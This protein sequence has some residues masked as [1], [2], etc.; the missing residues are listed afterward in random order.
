MFLTDINMTWLN[1]DIVVASQLIPINF[2]LLVK[3]RYPSHR[4]VGLALL[5]LYAHFSPLQHVSLRDET[6]FIYILCSLLSGS[7]T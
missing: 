4:S 2:E 1:G 5:F 6:T 3:N 7:H